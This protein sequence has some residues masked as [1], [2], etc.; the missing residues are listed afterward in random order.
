MLFIREDDPL[1]LGIRAYQMNEKKKGITGH[2][3]I[4]MVRPVVHDEPTGYGDPIIITAKEFQQVKQLNKISKTMELTFK[5]KTVDLFCDKDGVYSK[6]I[7]L[8]DTDD[9]DDEDDEEDEKDG[10]EEDEYK[11]TYD[12]DKILDLVKPASTSNNI[13]IWSAPDLPLHVSLNAGAN[14]SV[15]VYIK[16]R[17]IIEEEEDEKE[18]SNGSDNVT[19]EV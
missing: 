16:S 13:Q 9:T 4:T 3:N 19:L 11:Q 5:G 6:G 10:D 7:S 17:E 1:K 15:D 18:S 12:S 14:G 2:V 8:G